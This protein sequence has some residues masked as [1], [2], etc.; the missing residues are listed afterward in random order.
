MLDALSQTRPRIEVDENG[1]MCRR[2]PRGWFADS[3]RCVV[4]CLSIEQALDHLLGHD[5]LS[6]YNPSSNIDQNR[7]SRKTHCASDNVNPFV[8]RPRSGNQKVTENTSPP[9][10]NDD[11]PGFEA[12]F[13]ALQ[14]IL[15][16]GFYDDA[17]RWRHGVTTFWVPDRSQPTYAW[18]G[19][20]KVRVPPPQ[21]TLRIAHSILG[22][23]LGA[24]PGMHH[25]SVFAP[26]QHIYAVTQ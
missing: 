15:Y 21:P 17:L 26:R 13:E 22:I 24:P 4:G 16:R 23:I 7:C 14:G 2:I 8:L 10:E 19:A 18:L 6:V 3:P 5:P 11:P 12:S 1:G 20:N 9:Q 25:S